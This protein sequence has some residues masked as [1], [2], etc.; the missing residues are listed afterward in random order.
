MRRGRTRW[1][2][3]TGRGLPLHHFTCMNTFVHSHAPCIHMIPPSYEHTHT[4]IIALH[5]HLVSLSW[6]F[7]EAGSA[8]DELLLA[9][10]STRM[11]L[12]HVCICVSWNPF[13]FFSLIRLKAVGGKQRQIYWSSVDLKAICC[14]LRIMGAG[15]A[16]TYDAGIW[17]G[18]MEHNTMRCISSTSH[19]TYTTLTA[20]DVMAAHFNNHLCSK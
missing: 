16:C 6:S 8:A 13:P 10:L 17:E 7:W 1:S 20:G 3:K 4:V 18:A 12:Q 5:F 19:C 2:H 11:S 9:C 15:W 14:S